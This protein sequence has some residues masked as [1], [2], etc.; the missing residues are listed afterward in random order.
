MPVNAHDFKAGFVVFAVMLVASLIL[1]ACGGGGGGSETIIP[2][3]DPTSDPSRPSIFRLVPNSGPPGTIVKIEGVHFGDEIGTSTVSYNGEIL[4]VLTDEEGKNLWSDTSITIAIPDDAVTGLVIV[5]KSGKQSY[6][7]KNAKFIV[8]SATPPP[9]GDPV[10]TQLSPTSG[11]P[12]TV[13]TITGENFG[14]SRGSSTVRIGSI[15]CEI[16]TKLNPETG[17]FEER[18]GESNI[19]VIVPAKSEFGDENAPDLLPQVLSLVVEVGSIQSNSNFKFTVEDIDPTH[20]PVIITSVTPMRGEVGQTIEIRGQN[21][22]NQ[23]GASYVTFNG[24]RAK[25]VSWSNTI[26]NINVPAGAES[27]L[28][29]ITVNDTAYPI[30]DYEPEVGLTYPIDFEVIAAPQITGVSPVN[31]ILGDKVTL[32]GAHLGELPGS[33]NVEMVTGQGMTIEADEF[34]AGDADFVWTNATVSFIMPN[35]IPVSISKGEFAPGKV[36]LT[37]FDSRMSEDVTLSIK[38]AFDGVVE[39]NFIAA[40]R[41]APITFTVFVSG[42]LPSEYSYTWDFGDGGTGTGQSL[43]HAFTKK[44]SFTPEV[45][46]TSNKSGQASIFIGPAVEIGEST[47]PAIGSLKV[48]KVNAVE[49]SIAFSGTVIRSES[50]NLGKRITHLGDHITIQGYNLGSFEGSMGTGRVKVTR[51]LGGSEYYG[52]VVLDTD[53]GNFAWTQDEITGICTIVFTLSEQDM[54]MSGDVGI[55]TSEGVDSFNSIKLIVEPRIVAVAPQPTYVNSSINLICN[56]TGSGETQIDGPTDQADRI[57]YLFITMDGT[58]FIVNPASVGNSS[59]TFDLSTWNPIDNLG[60][61]IEKTPGTWQFRLWSSVLAEG[62]S[63]DIVNSGVISPEVDAVIA[64]AP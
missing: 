4:G 53:T 9:E 35:D 63:E 61:P 5:S 33:L 64:A 62:S 41:G 16:N 7:S 58:T 17:E 24:V 23:I 36:K 47:D 8:G 48:T 20:M 59:V 54:S 44:G 11:Q 43:G 57:L 31:V 14:A 28:L 34:N 52:S 37:T 46:A 60:Q 2:P 51:L 1:S 39:A 26:L 19:E 22:G 42:G 21:F 49:P 13:L 30:P 56:D 32:H 50:P 15:V 12:G 55:V 27:G 3:V 10:I 18:W 25:V 38:N 45:R 40:P 29:L 6:A